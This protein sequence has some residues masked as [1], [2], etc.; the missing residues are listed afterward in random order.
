MESIGD[1]LLISRRRIEAAQELSLKTKN[2][3]GF[4]PSR[5]VL[6]KVGLTV[7][8]ALHGW[9]DLLPKS[10]GLIKTFLLVTAC[11]MCYNNDEIASMLYE[12]MWLS[13]RNLKAPYLP[14]YNL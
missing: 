2:Q 5:K 3:P 9:P 1:S 7:G 11:Q 10:I 14:E 13:K 4:W 12:M 6:R 8:V